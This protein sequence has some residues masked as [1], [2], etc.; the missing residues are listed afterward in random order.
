MLFWQFRTGLV[1]WA[2]LTESVRMPSTANQRQS[3]GQTRAEFSMAAR[4]E[5]PGHPDSDGPAPEASVPGPLAVSGCYVKASVA[6]L[7]TRIVLFSWG[8]PNLGF[9]GSAK[10]CS[11]EAS[12]VSESSPPPLKPSGRNGKAKLSAQDACTAEGQGLGQALAT[13]SIQIC[14]L[15]FN[16]GMCLAWSSTCLLCSGFSWLFRPGMASLSQGTTK[17]I[18]KD[19]SDYQQRQEWPGTARVNDKGREA[20]TSLIRRKH[21]DARSS[22]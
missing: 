12:K 2:S 21:H 14:A 16:P 11:P 22:I 3:R 20:T 15:N 18:C 17:E 1:S 4:C 19:A 7:L 10:A 9:P 13:L 6:P 5:W 8:L